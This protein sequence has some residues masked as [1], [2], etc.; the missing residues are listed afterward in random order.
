MFSISDSEE[1]IPLINFQPSIRYDHV[2]D[3]EQDETKMAGHGPAA[4]SDITIFH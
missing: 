3:G 4:I 1:Q 2:V